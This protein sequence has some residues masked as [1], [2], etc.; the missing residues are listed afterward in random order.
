MFS[1]YVA[2]FGA[3]QNQNAHVKT[4]DSA[5]KRR[6][7]LLPNVGAFEVASRLIATSISSRTKS[8][9]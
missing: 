3:S 4:S 5:V 8:T 2:G 6:W 9:E 1:I 7:F